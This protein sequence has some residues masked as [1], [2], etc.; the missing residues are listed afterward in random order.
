MCIG[1]ISSHNKLTRYELL[2]LQV[3]YLPIVYPPEIKQENALHFAEN[4]S[5]FHPNKLSV[6]H[7][8]ESSNVI[9][10]F[11]FNRPAMLWHMPLMLYRLLILMPIQ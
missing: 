4:V 7:H 3:E 10:T 2:I 1:S 9:L 11:C 8:V 5:L 6:Q